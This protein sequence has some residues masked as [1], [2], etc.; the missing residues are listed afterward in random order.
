[1]YNFVCRLFLSHNFFVYCKWFSRNNSISGATS[2]KALRTESLENYII[3]KEICILLW[4][5]RSMAKIWQRDWFPWNNSRI[6]GSYFYVKLKTTVFRT[7][8]RTF[9]IW[10]KSYV[11]Q[12]TI[13]IWFKCVTGEWNIFQKCDIIKNTTQFFLNHYETWTQ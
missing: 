5:K 11:F 8:I 3:T 2:L 12:I 6:F 10:R 1:M 4:Q 9:A 13:I 7:F